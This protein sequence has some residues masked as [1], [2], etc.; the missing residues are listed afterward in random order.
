L[1]KF[2]GLLFSFG[3]EATSSGDDSH[4]L[5]TGQWSLRAGDNAEQAFATQDH[6]SH[7]V[8]VGKAKS[9]D[10]RT[11]RMKKCTVLQTMLVQ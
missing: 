1:I 2:V 11:G 5:R 4:M 7:C 3:V 6:V 8:L 9:G 10:H